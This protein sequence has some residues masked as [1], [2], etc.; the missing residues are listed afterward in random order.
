MPPDYC[1]HCGAEVPSTARACPECGSDEQ[2]GW[3]DRAHTDRL[4]LPDDEFVYDDF[5]KDEFRGRK[6]AAAQ[7]R[8]IG[9]LWWMVAI[10]LVLALLGILSG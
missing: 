3:S 5:V 6:A 9:W 2:T 1:P 4:G 7:P 8:G 10:V